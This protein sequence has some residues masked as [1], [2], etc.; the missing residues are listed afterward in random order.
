MFEARGFKRPSAAK[1]SRIE[2]GQPIPV[3]MLS[4]FEAIT[5]IPAKNLAPNVASIF[6]RKE[7]EA[8]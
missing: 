6:L 1:L 5:G 3:E 8:A 4:E 7:E 2:R